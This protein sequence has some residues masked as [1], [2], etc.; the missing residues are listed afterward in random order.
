MSN[1]A[2][3]ILE[4]YFALTPLDRAYKKFSFNRIIG[5]ILYLAQMLN[6]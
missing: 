4:V 5:L 2:F 1:M 6:I 3:M